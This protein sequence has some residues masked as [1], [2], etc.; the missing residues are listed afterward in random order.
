MTLT[1]G[2][3]SIRDTFTDGDQDDNLSRKQ[4]NSSDEGNT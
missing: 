3:S 4:G 2:K 1:I